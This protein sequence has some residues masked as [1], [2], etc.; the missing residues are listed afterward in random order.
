[1][2][3]GLVYLP[4]AEQ[5]FYCAAKA[6]LHSYTQSLGWALRQSAVEV[7]EISLPLVN[8]NFHQ[9]DLPNN[10]QSIQPDK[11]AN[12]ALHGIRNGKRQVYVGKAALARWLSVIAP[13]K[14]MAIVN[15]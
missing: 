15:R 9:C 6:A 1:M 11:A 2:T 14:G 13:D 12:K 8:T 3:T 4:K 7:Y 5:A 10:I